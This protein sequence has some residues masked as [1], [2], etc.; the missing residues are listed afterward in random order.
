[1][2]VAEWRDLLT[3]LNVEVHVKPISS[4]PDVAK[5]FNTI[6]PDWSRVSNIWRYIEKNRF[7]FHYIDGIPQW[8]IEPGDAV[9]EV[10]FGVPLGNLEPQKVRDCVLPILVGRTGLEPVTP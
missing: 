5:G 3:L 2:S 4:C 6:T 1:M 8:T 9:I 7:S 10:R